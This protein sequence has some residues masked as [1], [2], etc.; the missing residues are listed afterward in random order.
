MSKAAVGTGKGK[1]EKRAKAVVQSE[2][3]VPDYTQIQGLR[4][5]EIVDLTLSIAQA[6]EKIVKLKGLIEEWQT[7]ILGELKSTGVKSVMVEDYLVT[8]IDGTSVK[9]SREKL[10]ELGVKEKILEKATTRTPWTGL[11]ITKKGEKGEGGEGNGG[12][13]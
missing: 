7:E 9:L 10:F 6:K 3:Q 1:A 2:T 12:G 13:E 8:R 5:G 4:G 11:K